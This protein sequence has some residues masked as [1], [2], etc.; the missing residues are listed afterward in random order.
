MPPR[1][2]SFPSSWSSELTADSSPPVGKR[3]LTQRMARSTTPAPSIV[4]RPPGVP[5]Q[6]QLDPA[7][8][9][10]QRKQ[11]DDDAAAAMGFLGGPAESIDDSIQAHA[12]AGIAGSGQALPHLDAIQASFGPHDVSGVR[13]HVGGAAAEASGAIGAHAYATGNDVAFASQPDLFLAAHEA[14]HVVQQRQGVS[15]KSAVGEAGDAYEQHADEVAAAVVRGESVAELLGPAATGGAA[16]VQLKKDKGDSKA[17]VKAA[18]DRVTT[19]INKFRKNGNAYLG[20]FLKWQLHNEHA[21]IV[22]TNGNLEIDA[23]EGLLET[24]LA[25]AWGNF[26]TD[27]P[28]DL[29]GLGGGIGGKLTN[30]AGEAAATAVVESAGADVAGAVLTTGAQ[31]MAGRVLSLAG[32]SVMA[33]ATGAIVKGLFRVISDEAYR[34]ERWGELSKGVESGATQMAVKGV[35]AVYSFVASG[36]LFTDELQAAEMEANGMTTVAE[37]D[38]FAAAIGQ[39]KTPAGKSPTTDKS[40]ADKMVRAWVL[41][42]ADT[43]KKGREEIDSEKW[44]KELANPE[45]SG[46]SIEKMLMLAAEDRYKDGQDKGKEVPQRASDQLWWY[47]VRRILNDAGCLGDQ[48]FEALASGPSMTANNQVWEFPELPEPN[49]TS[50]ARFAGKH[51]PT[52]GMYSASKFAGAEFNVKVTCK[53]E[54]TGL[55]RN[56]ASMT[57]ESYIKTQPPRVFDTFTYTP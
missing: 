38:A 35:D 19:A 36:D 54:G 14:A 27:I 29:T 42:N 3:A 13:A 51:G 31:K 57:F 30:E 9:A 32:T 41:E 4:S 39:W 20:G 28:E 45:V 50:F 34:D 21:F 48:V 46:G 56:V 53:L 5:V 1:F 49:S 17:A 40:L 22:R 16:A 15:L 12:A 7:A 25:D 11:Q 2:D 44:N 55:T 52:G 33:T 24:F 18:R 43:K 8:A 10:I 26:W 23:P 37:L 6:R 47:Q